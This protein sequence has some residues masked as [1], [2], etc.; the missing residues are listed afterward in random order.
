VS[1]LFVFARNS[2]F[3]YKDTATNIQE[4]GQELGADYVLEGSVRKSNGSVR[5]TAQ[6][7]DATTGGHIWAE[8][9]D[10]DMED[11]FTLQ[12]DVVE[13][14]VSALA[15]TLSDDEKA[16]LHELPTSNL[17]AYDFAQKGWWYY[18]Q[19]T[20]E[21]NDTARTLFEKAIELD[22]QYANAIAG[23][24]FTYYETWPQ[25]WSSD[26]LA[27]DKAYELATEAIFLDDSLSQA[28]SLL[29]HV[30]LWRKQHALAIIQIERA[31]ELEPNNSFY[32]RDLGEILIFAG[33]PEEAIEPLE[34]AIELEPHYPISFPF[35]LGFAYALVGYETDSPSS[36]DLAIE[37]LN[38]AISLNPEFVNAYLV[39]AFVHGAIGDNVRAC[40]YLH[41]VSLIN[42]QLMS[43]VVVERL[44]FKDPSAADVILGA[45]ERECPESDS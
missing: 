2:T 16:L 4:I 19:L 3:V 9:Y 5:I 11:I 20:K 31:L 27:L 12:D 15:L 36:Y 37:S 1:G 34:R 18:H 45:I 10:R 39:L 26:N 30:Y 42:P 6:L 22:P 41:E 25:F 7:I 17:D 29:S 40:E 23:L 43:A 38:E 21:S 28:Y 14:I 35:T 13:E 44:P 24:G 32:L 33:R 8:K